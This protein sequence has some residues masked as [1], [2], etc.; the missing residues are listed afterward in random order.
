M[1][2]R[3]H[4]KRVQAKVSKAPRYNI[5]A[6]MREAA[7]QKAAASPMGTSMLTAANFGE[8]VSP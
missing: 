7:R 3:F 1:V 6:I 5:K 8:L 4:S 2:N